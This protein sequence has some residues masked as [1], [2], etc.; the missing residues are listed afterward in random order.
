MGLR[1]NTNLPNLIA[2]RN[3][4]ATDRGLQTT[5]RRLASG[6]RLERAQDDPAA[7]S[8]AD[9]LRSDL[10]ALR[11][12]IENASNASNLVA[13]ADAAVQEIT[14][15]V[16][17]LQESAIF[18]LSTGSASPAQIAAEQAA[19]DSTIEAIRRIAA[20]TRFNGVPLLNGAQEIQ[21]L[22]ADP[23]I[24]QVRPFRVLFN[25]VS[26][27]TTMSVTL[28]SS[29]EQA[30]GV[31]GVGGVAVSGGAVTLRITGP[32]GTQEIRLADGATVADAEAAVNETR[33]FTGVYASGGAFFTE[34][35]GAAA[36]VRVENLGP[37]TFN[38]GD[39]AAPGLGPGQVYFDRGKNAVVSFQGQTV[40]GQGNT[41]SLL[42]PYF[43]GEILFEPF[44]PPAAYEFTLAKSGMRFQIKDDPQFVHESRVGIPDL[45]PERVG[46]PETVV[47]GR[48]FG[49]FLS[50]LVSGRD[51]DLFA[52]PGRALEIAR[53]AVD[54][55]ST[56]R[57]R[58]G[59]L[60]S[61][62]F[63]AVRG[64]VEVARENL[65]ASLS[66]LR[67]A[68]I[69]AEAAALAR[70]QVLFQAGVSVLGQAAELP[71]QVLRLLG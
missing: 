53:E 31:L 45:S 38:G 61:F 71:A 19:V 13:T 63:E 11:R 58:L 22:S 30:A 41:V 51:A 4:A 27:S 66:T 9:G 67:D 69:A 43:Q 65:A 55:L 39:P 56:I 16:A 42:T 37:G 24:L 46:T 36:F 25:P 33:G 21:V 59:A 8:V 34:T 20:T 23:G 40:S 6:V 18:A 17:R 14:D 3:L 47:G 68:D 70:G 54:I 7:M 50:Q 15:L 52:A 29:A 60:Q 44:A 1:I 26:A 48:V 5:F 32:L 57:S 64:A 10:E 28:V 35:F 62:E 2:L 12:L 49:G